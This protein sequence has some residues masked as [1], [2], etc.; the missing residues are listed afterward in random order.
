MLKLYKTPGIFKRVYPDFL[1]HKNTSS[2]HLTFDDGPH[3][4]ITPWV[5]DEL[6]KNQIKATF[7]VLGKHV[8]QH[9]DL[10]NRIIADGHAIGNHSMNHIK[11]R[12]TS[13]SVYI[14]DVL[15][16]R[17]IVESNLFR[18]PYGSITN[19][20]K[21]LLIQEGFKIVMW[22]VIAYDW[23]TDFDETLTLEKLV[24]YSKKGS[25]I[26]FH[27]SIKAADNLKKVLPNYI[28]EILEKGLNFDKL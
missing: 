13:S 11:G 6:K 5:L 2:V 14:E 20:Q 28:H 3:P 23:I 15:M 9:P 17:E 10:Y 4:E 24:S 21:K 25:I 22:D 27:D 19:R 7:F 1:W 18:P 26:V 16:C 8:K 12:S